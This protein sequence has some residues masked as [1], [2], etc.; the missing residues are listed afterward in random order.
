[1]TLRQ[2]KIRSNLDGQLARDQP[3]TAINTIKTNSN[4]SNS[5]NI[6]N[7]NDIPDAD[8]LELSSLPLIQREEFID[9]VIHGYDTKQMLI[10]SPLILACLATCGDKTDYE[11]I[12]KILLESHLV[13]FD[14]INHECIL[15]RVL[16]YMHKKDYASFQHVQVYRET[17]I[18]EPSAFIFYQFDG[19][20]VNQDVKLVSGALSGSSVTLNTSKND[21][22]FGSDD[23]HQNETPIS[24][25]CFLTVLVLR[26]IFLQYPRWDFHLLRENIEEHFVELENALGCRPTILYPDGDIISSRKRSDVTWEVIVKYHLSSETGQ[27]LYM[28]VDYYFFE[29]FGDPLADAFANV[30]QSPFYISCMTDSTTMMDTIFDSFFKR[31][32][33]HCWGT[34]AQRHIEHC[35]GK[36]RKKKLF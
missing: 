8:E 3:S 4:N 23:D 32:N 30:Y 2:Q 10:P 31:R 34:V 17:E 35:F 6:T 25:R 1:M 24:L 33:L 15:N 36:E 19:F 9:K 12:V 22:S 16:H 5:A 14:G 29:S 27:S 26:D 20:I 28:Q 18:E 7:D 21:E 11:E 13:E